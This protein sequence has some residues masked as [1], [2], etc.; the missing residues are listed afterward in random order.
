MEKLSH[1]QITLKLAKSYI[2]K[3]Q[4]DKFQ[5]IVEKIPLEKMN[6]LNSNVLL[7]DFLNEAYN[8]QNR[9]V[10]LIIFESWQ[11]IYNLEPEISIYSFL[12]TLLMI[13]LDAFKFAMLSF[14]DITY[15][16]IM[17]D[18]IVFDK[19]TNVLSACNRALDVYGD[20]TYENY[21]LLRDEA[22]KEENFVIEDFMIAKMEE[23]ASFKSKPDWVKN[24]S[25]EVLQ[26]E[27]NLVIPKMDQSRI[28]LPSNEEAAIS[29][30]KKIESQLDEK[31]LESEGKKLE[32][33]TTDLDAFLNFATR[34]EKLQLF[35]PIIDV[36][37]LDS[38][39][40]EL[41]YYKKLSQLYGPVNVPPNE[42][43][44]YD[45]PND[46]NDDHNVYRMF[47]CNIYDYDEDFGIIRPW[48]K[49]SCDY[50]HDRIHYYWYALRSPHP[51]GGWLGCYCSFDCVRKDS[52]P[53]DQFN[54]IIQSMIN[55]AEFRINQIGIQDRLP[56]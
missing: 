52:D 55:T 48:F 5:N 49:G 56:L 2:Q 41:D 32:S 40:L 6:D 35:E 28:I 53:E 7:S 43:F 25:D 26:V 19:T 29:L 22:K 27:N 15:T 14:E 39:K 51:Y 10:I 23:T 9:D 36:K 8:F 21:K 42:D 3:N 24:Y 45:E 50:C 12:F 17:L 30:N 54:N 31:I 16:E 33:V 37:D 34:E 18:L 44:D 38:L 20:Q 13:P 47:L 46:D 4:N 11:R 1:A